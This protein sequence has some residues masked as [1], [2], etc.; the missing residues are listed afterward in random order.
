VFLKVLKK[1]VLSKAL[2]I[3]HRCA[4]HMVEALRSFISCGDDTASSAA[5][6][7]FSFSSFFLSIVFISC[8]DDTSSSAAGVV[9]FFSTVPLYGEHTR[10]IIMTFESFLFFFA[11]GKALLGLAR[12]AV[13]QVSC[14]YTHTHT[15]THTT[16]TFV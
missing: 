11:A 12:V 9:L 15:Q 2:S 1:I 5:G 8:G 4:P 7:F 13:D 16:H 14:Y 10:L 6:A 3:D